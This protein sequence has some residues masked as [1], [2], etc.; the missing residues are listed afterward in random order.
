MAYLKKL[1]KRKMFRKRTCNSAITVLMVMTGYCVRLGKIIE[2][3]AVI[4]LHMM[5][6]R[7]CSFFRN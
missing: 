3:E 7:D 1:G 2:N 6:E 5:Q 4:L